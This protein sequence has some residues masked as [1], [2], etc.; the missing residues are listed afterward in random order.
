MRIEEREYIE[1][2]QISDEL[3]DAMN[4]VI[5]YCRQHQEFEDCRYCALGD[6]IHN[7]GCSSPWLW[8]IRR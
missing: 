3:V 6:G 8:K 1:P 7:C 4:K 2:E 5:E